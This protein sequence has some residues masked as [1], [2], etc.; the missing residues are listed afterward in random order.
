[1]SNLSL[2]CMFGMYGFPVELFKY[3]Y[4]SIEWDDILY[5][6]LN[7]G[8][9]NRIKYICINL[10]MSNK[11]F[12]TMS[13]SILFTVRWKNTLA[14]S[15]T[16]STAY[17]LVLGITYTTFYSADKLLHQHILLFTKHLSR[18]RSKVKWLYL[19]G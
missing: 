10:I 17:D 15:Y 2:I 7:R 19:T 12:M 8:G 16:M 11:C 4:Y 9:Q 18:C 6:L 3:K 1:M 14:L 13:M 5:S